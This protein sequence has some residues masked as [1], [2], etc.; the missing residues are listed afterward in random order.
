[1]AIRRG[2][3]LAR[4]GRMIRLGGIGPE[5]AGAILLYAGGRPSFVVSPLTPIHPVVQAAPFDTRH[6]FN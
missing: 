2:T 3:P 4:V 1:V 5:T 6:C